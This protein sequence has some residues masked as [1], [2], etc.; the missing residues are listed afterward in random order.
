[1]QQVYYEFNM[2][3]CWIIF[4]FF[5]YLIYYKIISRRHCDYPMFRQSAQLSELKDAK[6]ELERAKDDLQLELESQLKREAE[7][8]LFT[9]RITMKNSQLQSEN[10]HLTTEVTKTVTKA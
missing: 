2:A 7:N 10:L 3:Y 6:N 9:E 4:R 1:M 8:L 5:S